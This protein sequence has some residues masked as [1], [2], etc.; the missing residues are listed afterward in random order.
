MKTNERAVC[1][2]CDEVI[3]TANGG[4]SVG[5]TFV[6]FER[7]LDLHMEQRHANVCVLPQAGEVLRRAA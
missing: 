3:A 4:R 5:G 1:S 2:L 7:L 6:A